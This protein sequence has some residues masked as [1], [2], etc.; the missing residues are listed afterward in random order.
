MSSFCNHTT[1]CHCLSTMATNTPFLDCFLPVPG[2]HAIPFKSWVKIFQNYCLVIDVEGQE[3]TGARQRALLLHC[4]GTEGQRIFYTLPNTGDT[5]ATALTSLHGYFTPKVNVVVERHTFRKQVQLAD[6]SI[7]QYVTALRQLAATCEF[8]NGDDMIRDQLV[9]HVAHARIRERLL[10]KQKLT[11]EDAV[12]IASQMESAGEQAKCMTKSGLPVQAVQVHSTVQRRQP[13]KNARVGSSTGQSTASFTPATN[14]RACFRCGSDK[15]LAN[16]PECPASTAV[17]KTCNKRGH[18]SRVCRS[19]AQTHSVRE[20]DIPEYTLFMLQREESPAKL[21]CTVDI[22]AGT[23]QKTVTLTVDTGASVSVLPQGIVEKYFKG[24][25]LQPPAARLV[26]YSQTPIKVLGCMPATVVRDNDACKVNFYVTDNGTPLMGMDLIT[27][28]KL[29]IEGC[30]LLSASPASRPVMQL[31]TASKDS[32]AMGCAKGF[33]HKVKISESASPVRQKLRRLPF[34]VRS[35]VSDELN[36]LLSSG[37]I[38][39]IDA[40]PWVSPIVVTQKKTGGI[41]MCVDLREPNKAIV[42]DSH[43]LPH[44]DELLA[45]LA[46]SILFSTIDLESAYHQLPL[47]PD[48]R[49]LTAF[50]THEGL[51][52]FCRVPYGLASAPA[53]FQKMMSVVLQG[54]PNVQ[55]YLDDIICFGSTQLQHD[56]ALQ[57]VLQRLKKAGL[58]IN[59][60]KCQYRQPS[61]RFLGHIVTAQGIEPDT[62]HVKA[63]TQAPP[64]KDAATLRSLLG[65]LSWYNKFL[66]NYATVVEPLRA[67]LRSDTEY[68]WTAEADKCFGE[69]KQLLLDSSALALYDPALPSIVSSDASDYGIGAVFTQIHPNNIERTVAFASRTL[70]QTERKYATVEKEALACVWAVEKWRT[71]L[72]GHRFTLRTDHQ[73]LTTLLSTKGADRAGMRIARWS[74]RLLCFNYDVIYRAGTQNQ[75]ADCLSRLPLLLLL[76]MNQRLSPSWL[77]CSLQHKLLLRLLSSSLLLQYAPSSLH[78]AHRSKKDGLL[79]QNQ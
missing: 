65:M 42:V 21:N 45:T 52:R 15:H 41:R 50:I 24:V 7:I 78:C 46:G 27:A 28:L 67:C 12:T 72:W 10:L 19:A 59:E 69:V 26:T 29:R 11:L 74:A 55:N 37:V 38:E 70:T 36:K 44:M 25:T 73:A 40:S 54:V 43:P 58:R 31:A 79:L 48:S 47:H 16:A 20:V 17:C 35:A 4:L 2:E 39:R 64:P 63:I 18:F 62:D 51:F 71:Y 3:W 13:W 76:H 75:T 30:T 61:L 6:E 68:K 57:E 60:K 5:L 66:P 22:C 56:A 32:P 53:A 9:E 49:D 23:M 1:R 77:H 14:S 33:M 8:A 34:A